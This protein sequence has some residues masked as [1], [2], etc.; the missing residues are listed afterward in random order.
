MS[1]KQSEFLIQTTTTEA[2]SQKRVKKPKEDQE[3]IKDINRQQ[4]FVINSFL[5]LMNP[6]VNFGIIERINLDY[7]IKLFESKTRNRKINIKN[8]KSKR[9]LLK[10]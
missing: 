3:S 5:G 7:I 2:E 6:K 1:I 4:Q 10:V 9:K 8:S